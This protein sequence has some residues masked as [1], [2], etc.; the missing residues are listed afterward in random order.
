MGRARALRRPYLRGRRGKR[1]ALLGYQGESSTRPA[2][3]G[4]QG[5]SSTVSNRRDR[6]RDTASAAE[7]MRLFAILPG[8]PALAGDVDPRLR[9][10]PKSV[11]V[12]KCPGNDACRGLAPNHG[13]GNAASFGGM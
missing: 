1:P 8:P 2:L 11:L 5:E 13:A 6:T 12:S 7:T 9:D 4:Y 3:P 10:T